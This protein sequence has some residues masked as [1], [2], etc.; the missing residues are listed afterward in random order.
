MT[1][2]QAERT[3]RDALEQIA[4]ELDAASITPGDELRA[5][6]DL[7]SMDFLNLVVAISQR[8]GRDIPESDYPD[9]ATFGQLVSYL[10]K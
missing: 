2:D 10:T 7:D 9:L 4:P 5:D 8:A 3:V 6:L 1:P